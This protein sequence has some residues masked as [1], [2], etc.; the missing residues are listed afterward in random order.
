MRIDPLGEFTQLV[1]RRLDILADL[2]E[3]LAQQ[4]VTGGQLADEP[5]PDAQPNQALLRP[6]MQIAPQHLSLPVKRPDHPC[7]QDAPVS[8]RAGAPPKRRVGA[9]RRTQDVLGQHAAQCGRRHS[10]RHP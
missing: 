10:A 5:E 8:A 7:H 4:C 2:V 1:D 9:R 3:Q 6:V